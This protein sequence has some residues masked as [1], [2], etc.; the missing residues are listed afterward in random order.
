MRWEAGWGGRIAYYHRDQA[1]T[2]ADLYE[3]VHR[4]AAA[5]RALGVAAGDRVLVRIADTPELVYTVLATHAIGAVA[6]PTYI[7][8][9]PR[10][11]SIGWRIPGRFAFAGADL[12]DEMASAHVLCPD[13]TVV[14]LP[15]D[16]RGRSDRW[17][18]FCPTAPRR[19]TTTTATPRT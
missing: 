15:A 19:P 13:V 8:F 6:I 9:A 17:P 10:T 3:A 4:Y 14:V 12:L 18:I 1:I 16:L 2:Y 5:M 7:S 11:W